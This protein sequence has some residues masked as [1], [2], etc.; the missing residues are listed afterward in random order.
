VVQ[1]VWHVRNALRQRGADLQ[2]APAQDA[3]PAEDV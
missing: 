2:Q 3:V 1:R